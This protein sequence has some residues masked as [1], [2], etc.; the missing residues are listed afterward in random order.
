MR[1]LLYV[2]LAAV[3]VAGIYACDNDPEVYGDFS[4]KPELKLGKAIVSQN[5]GAE[6]PLVIAREFD[7]TYRYSYEVYDTLKDENGI[8]VLDN[9]GKLQ[10]TTTEEYYYSKRTG[11]IVEYEKIMFPSYEDLEFDTVRLDIVSNSNWRA[12]MGVAVNW[13]NNVGSTEKGGGDGTFSFSIK[14]FNNEVSKYE[15]VQEIFTN[16]S[17]AMYRFTF[18]HYGLKYTGQ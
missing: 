6:Y 2:A 4:L 17:S 10:I 8:P 15:V 13:Y 9:K 14:R 16:D 11:H 18:G 12:P 3:A 7:S 1:K 5:T